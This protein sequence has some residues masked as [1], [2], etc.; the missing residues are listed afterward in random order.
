MSVEIENTESRFDTLKLLLALSLVVSAIAGFYYFA[1]QS[2]L[3]RVIGMLVVFSCSLALIY[4]TSIGQQFWGFLQGSRVELK[5]VIW[6]TR[7]ETVQTTLIVGVMVLFIG[8]LLWMFDSLLM[9]GIGFV[10]GQGG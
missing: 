2:N 7:K 10:T 5:K 1:E 9:W 4:M 6:P 3:L 8:I